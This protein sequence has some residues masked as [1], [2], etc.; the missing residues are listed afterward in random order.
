MDAILQTIFSDACSWMKSFIFWL[1]CHWSLFLT[2]LRIN[3]HWF[4]YG[5]VPNR[6]QAIIW[7]NADIIHW[8]IYVELR[9]DELIL[10]GNYNVQVYNVL[11]EMLI[12]GGWIFMRTISLL[13]LCVGN[14]SIKWIHHPRNIWWNLG[15]IIMII[16]NIS[17]IASFMWPTWVL[18][19]PGGPHVGPM[20]LVIRDSLKKY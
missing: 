8:H 18:S 15:D 5:L 9:G 2:Q 13:T 17:Q 11:A 3:Q 12:S 1:K 14:P 4:R 20:N 10:Y 19:A 6:Q 7:T 16:F